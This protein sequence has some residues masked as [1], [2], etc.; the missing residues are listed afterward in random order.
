MR[1]KIKENASRLLRKRRMTPSSAVQILFNQIVEKGDLPFDGRNAPTK[2]EIE[3]RLS[4]FK[5]L[6]LSEGIQ[7]T[8][9]EIKSARIRDRYGFDVG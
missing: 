8:D 1:A 3:N 5:N 7:M 6:Q 4:A 9:K 2:K